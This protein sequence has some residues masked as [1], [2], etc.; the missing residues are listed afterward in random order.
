MLSASVGLTAVKGDTLQLEFSVVD[1]VG[2][3][4]NITGSSPLFAL[5]R[6]REDDPVVESPTSATATV[7]NGPD[8]VF[9]VTVAAT[10]TELLDGLYRF[11]ALLVDLSGNRQTVSI[12]TI[13]FVDQVLA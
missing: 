7:T 13:N 6:L 2:A 3:V 11:Q 5:S 1:S 12:G 10:V 8:G 4:A 9:R